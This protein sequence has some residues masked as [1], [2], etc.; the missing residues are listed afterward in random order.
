MNS[1][2]RSSSDSNW[3]SSSNTKRESKWAQMRREDGESDKEVQVRRNKQN[4][5]A[6]MAAAMNDDACQSDE[7]LLRPQLGVHRRG[8]QTLLPMSSSIYF[9]MSSRSIRTFDRSRTEQAALVSHLIRRF[10]KTSTSASQ[11]KKI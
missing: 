9:V 4:R 10:T 5:A 3:G 1:N 2:F 6:A 8:F 11:I 7:Q